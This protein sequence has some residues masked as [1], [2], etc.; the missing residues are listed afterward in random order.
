VPQIEVSFDIDANGIV[1]VKAKDK[2]TGKEQKITITASSGLSK[3]EIE[4]MKKDAESHAEED[5]KKREL[6]EAKNIAE[7][8]VYTAEKT[9]KD[10]GDKVD[11]NK[12]S[13]V[14][15]KIKAVRDALP[16]DNLEVI[17]EMTRHFRNPCRNW[18]P[19]CISSKLVHS[20]QELG[21][22]K[23]SQRIRRKKRKNKLS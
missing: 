15:E 8:L 4:K 20:Q 14:E 6:I 7:S 23:E 17:K 19:R 12:K 16:G 9:L 3:E 13:E 22:K 10:A 5:K 21:R 1:N 2:A 11:S 18:V